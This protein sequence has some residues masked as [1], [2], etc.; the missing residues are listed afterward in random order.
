[1]TALP[2]RRQPP[3]GLLRRHFAGLVLLLMGVA[4]LLTWFLADSRE[5]LLRHEQAHLDKLVQVQGAALQQQLAAG[6]GLLQ[7]VVFPEGRQRVFAEREFAR[8]A[9]VA[10]RDST[11]LL[12]DTRGR[13]IAGNRSELHGRAWPNRADLVRARGGA[14]EVV[15]LTS[16]P[17]SG[18]DGPPRFAL[19]RR[20][21]DSAGRFAGMAILAIEAPP[22]ARQLAT[23]LYA[24]DLRV[25]LEHADGREIVLAGASSSGSAQLVAATA[26]AVPDLA[27]SAQPRLILARDRAAVLAEWRRQAWWGGAL[28]L[29]VVVASLGAWLWHRRRLAAG[30]TL[31]LR[32]QALVDSASEGIYVLDGAGRVVDANPAF[33]SLLGLQ[34]QPAGVLRLEAFDN[35]LPDPEA[36]LTHLRGLLQG[37]HPARY[38]SVYRRVGGATLEVEVSTWILRD[39]NESLVCASFRDL[40]EQKRMLAQLAAREA[41]LRAILNSEPECVKVVGHDGRVLLM[42]PAGLQMV[43]ATGS[44]EVI[45]QPVLALIAPED[46]E[47]FAAFQ[48]RVL[49]G[50]PEVL[51]FSIVG[52]HGQRRRMES[53]AVPLR[54]DRGTVASVLAVTRD[55]S[56]RQQMLG[57]LR[58]LQQ[59]IEQS[60]EG[61]CITDARGVIEYVNPAFV[62]ASGYSR[63]ELLGSNPRML[64]SEQTAGR[65]Y[66]DLWA[67]L[68]AGRVWSGELVNRRKDGGLYVESEVI[69]PVFDETGKI[70]HYLAVKQDVTEKKRLEQE[71]EQHRSQLEQL[72]TQRTAELEQANSQLAEAR[73]QAAAA[74]RT[75][76]TF[77]SNM[78]HE[79]RTPMNGIIGLLHLAQRDAGSPRLKSCL[80]KMEH[81]AGHL[82]TLIND[83]LDLSKIDAGKLTLESVPVNLPAIVADVA[84]IVGVTA[85]SKNLELMTELAPLPGPLYGD[86]TRITQALLNY[87]SNA[88][89]F[90]AAGRVG[91]AVRVLEQSADSALL[92]L[93]VS[94]SGPGIAPEVLPR[95]FQ[96][97]E[98]ADSST[99]RIY[100]GTGLGLAIT[101]QLAGLMG[102]EVGVESLPGAGSTFWLTLRLA[103]HGETLVAEAQLPDELEVKIRENF[104][105]RRVLLAE[106]EPINQEIACALLEELGLA[107]SVAENGQRAVDLACSGDFSLIL[108]DMQMPVL[109]GLAATREIRRRCPAAPPIVAMTA[110][111]F[112]EDRERCRAAGMDDFIAKPIDLKKFHRTLWR[113]LHGPRPVL[114]LVAADERG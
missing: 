37:S 46:R 33:Y 29:A 111:A 114:R 48:Q 79:I 70:T 20:L 104:T 49:A 94:D 56:E 11:L 101:R 51:E 22:L 40:S 15:S 91:I 54:D 107:V 24:P 93:E 110:N 17:V 105:G 47:A 21:G 80:Q 1:M 52:L 92:R 65:V 74:A 30:M 44:D 43:G 75:K 8:L 59:A 27:A 4:G 53:H 113:A 42:N 86:P 10:G 12:L 100:K 97:F 35:A 3:G 23:L 32:K 13:V 71:L 36:V 108:M 76:A 34:P 109:D 67:T 9:A 81:A 85:R 73:D 2:H 72:V 14:E 88:V 31:L 6:A 55:V 63:E 90:T 102:G 112:S 64:R 38:A 69:S 87:A 25:R 95:L 68:V 77:L 5:R 18:G 39:G 98:Q 62:S 66:Q 96:A 61:V 57:E 50:E 58:R 45:G 78:S 7:A 19:S 84:S 41:E 28:T 82:L 16:L 89:K 83:I 26:L 106:D 103:R 99:T 60:P